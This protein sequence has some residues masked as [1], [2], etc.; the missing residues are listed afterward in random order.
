MF[1]NLAE[2]VLALDNFNMEVRGDVTCDSEECAVA[3]SVSHCEAMF[4]SYYKTFNGRE[5]KLKLG[6]RFREL[7]KITNFLSSQIHELKDREEVIT[8]HE[9]G[10]TT[11]GAARPVVQR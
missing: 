6:L 4:D 7:F 1:E 9:T 10:Q 3:C 8:H 11:E 2:V 5:G